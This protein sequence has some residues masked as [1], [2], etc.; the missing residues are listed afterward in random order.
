MAYPPNM[1]QC[2]RRIHQRDYL[3]LR[4]PSSTIQSSQT[5]LPVSRPSIIP[6]DNDPNWE[7]APTT[8]PITNLTA[9]KPTSST[10]SQSKPY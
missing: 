6:V 4:S 9:N 5:F 7:N 2:S 3:S 1:L 10:H 8:N